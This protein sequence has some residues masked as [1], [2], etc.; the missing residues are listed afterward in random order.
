MA[1][2]GIFAGLVAAIIVSALLAVA[3]GARKYRSEREFQDIRRYL[4]DNGAFRL[5]ASLDAWLEVTRRNYAAAHHHLG[6]LKDFPY[7]HRLR[8]RVSDLPAF[9]PI[10]SLSLTF[11]AIA[12]TTRLL[13]SEIGTL[14]SSAF[15]DLYAA[16]LNFQARIGQPIRAYYLRR[17]GLTDDE[18]LRW[19][20]ELLSLTETGYRTAGHYDPLSQLLGDAGLRFQEMQTPSF[21]GIGQIQG[22]KVILGLRGDVTQTLHQLQ[23]KEE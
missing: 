11:D 16:N 9:L 22:D 4:V 10:D 21:A 15:A 13:G 7:S 3:Y 20:R 5:K 17:N 14:M 23:S 2:F 8:P 6:Y 12:P 19:H 18:R 1:R